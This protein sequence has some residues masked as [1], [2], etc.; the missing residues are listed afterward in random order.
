MR[1]LAQAIQTAGST[2]K[3]AIRDALSKAVLKDSLLPGGSLKFAADGQ[4][5]YP[6][7]I[8][9]N[10]PGDKVGIVIGR[11]QPPVKQLCRAWHWSLISDMG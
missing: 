10:K 1:I 11:T 2:D 6:F 8:V 3:K 4:S 9:Q 7:V 5:D